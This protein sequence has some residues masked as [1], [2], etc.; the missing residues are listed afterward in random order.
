MHNLTILAPGISG[1][2]TAF[3]VFDI[4][5][6]NGYNNGN[7]IIRGRRGEGKGEGKGEAI[8]LA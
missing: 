6:L 3:L 5:L 4:V 7:K 8:A 2:P 1:M